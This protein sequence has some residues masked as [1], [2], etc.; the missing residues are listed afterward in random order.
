M[1]VDARSARALVLVAWSAFLL[2][3]WATGEVARYLGPRTQWVV[4]VGAVGLGLVTYAY[5]R[6]NGRRQGTVTRV[7]TREALGLAALL[8]PIV[9]GAVLANASLGAL[10]ASKKLGQRGI[11]LSALANLSVAG[12]SHP[13]FVQIDV[14]G[15]NPGYAK[16]SGLL[17]GRT[18]RLV[19]FVAGGP[20]G[21]QRRF[22]LARFYITCCVA[23]SVPIGVTVDPA[24]AGRASYR[25][26]EWLDVTA[27]LAQRG[28]EYVLM[29]RKIQ[30]VSAPKDPYL[31]F[32]S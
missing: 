18:V 7:R 19:G 3:L 29:A 17:A 26:D 13:D 15:H 1:T 21:P 12:A 4:P 6:E 10:A 30:H 20:S 23:D 11:D 8:L 25:K 9:A 5:C 31:T 24:T 22:Q 32:P 28:K 16:R 14:A 27:S 2:W